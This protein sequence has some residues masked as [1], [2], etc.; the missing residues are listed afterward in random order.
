MRAFLGWLL[1]VCGFCLT[2][3]L[4]LA[5]PSSCHAQG[6][7]GFGG[8]G[9]SGGLGGGGLSGGLGGFGGGGLAGFGGGIGGAFG[10]GGGG[11]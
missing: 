11:F 8:G 9:L 3:G 10:I 6:I 4:L 1:A 7:G 5:E 2:L